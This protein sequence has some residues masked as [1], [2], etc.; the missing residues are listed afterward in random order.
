MSKNLSKASQW[1]QKQIAVLE[2]KK[3]NL[4]ADAA[5]LQDEA[6]KITEEISG[7]EEVLEKLPSE[8]VINEIPNRE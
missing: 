5:D 7:L 6:F 1:I 2:A 8:K 3:T 4:L